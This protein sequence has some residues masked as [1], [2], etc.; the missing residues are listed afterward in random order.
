MKIRIIHKKLGREQAYGIADS[1]GIVY[2]DQRLKGKK[3]LEIVIHEV[4]HL[5]NPNDDEETIVEKSV[6]LCKVLW[7]LGYRRIDNSNDVPLQDGSK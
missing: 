1:D 7:R 5:L 3:H 4:E 6:T 2:I